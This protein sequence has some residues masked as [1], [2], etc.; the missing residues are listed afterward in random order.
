MH[1]LFFMH[2]VHTESGHISLLFYKHILYFHRD[3]DDEPAGGMPQ[4]P[5]QGLPVAHATSQIVQPAPTQATGFQFGSFPTSPS[6]IPMFA[7]GQQGG[8][9]ATTTQGQHPYL[10]QSKG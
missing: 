7:F 5:I 6:Q 4:N 8:A 1:L 2:N 10:S 9:T 3:V